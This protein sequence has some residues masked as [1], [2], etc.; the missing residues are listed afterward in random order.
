MQNLSFSAKYSA[1]RKK[2]LQFILVWGIIHSVKRNEAQ[3]MKKKIRWITET[4]I[5]LALLVILQAVTKSAGQLIT[6]SCVNAVLAVSVLVSGLPSGLTVALVSPFVAFL[7]GIGPQLLPIVPA[8]A[9]GNTVSVLMLGR[10]CGRKPPV[11]RRV[12]AVAGSAGAKFLT[13]YLVV[14]KLLCSILPLK[15]PQI[16]T[17]STMFAWPQL[18]TALIGGAAALMIVPVIRKALHR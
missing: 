1:G 15:Q 7:L 4:G 9:L 11:W 12:L 18:I 8:I 13:L 10:L 14:V 5:M 16:A 3:L 2:T 17:F 6:G